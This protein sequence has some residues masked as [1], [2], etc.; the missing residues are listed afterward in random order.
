MCESKILLILYEP[1]ARRKTEF[2][3]KENKGTADQCLSFQQLDS[4]VSLLN[5]K[6]QVLLRLFYM[7]YFK[8]AKFALDLF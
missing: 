5:M 3:L 8:P 1:D 2:R 4:T 6:Y 7:L